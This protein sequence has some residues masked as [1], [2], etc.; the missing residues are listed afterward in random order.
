MPGA[1]DGDSQLTLVSGAGTGSTAGQDL[2]ALG[3]VTADLCSVLVVCL[4]GQDEMYF[5][6]A[7]ALE[8]AGWTVVETMKNKL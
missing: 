8:E 5:G 6:T 1:L 7:G 4:L 2:A 3:Q